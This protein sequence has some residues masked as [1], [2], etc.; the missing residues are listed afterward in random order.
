MKAKFLRYINT[1]LE[2]AIMVLV[3]VSFGGCATKYGVG[4]EPVV[5]EYGAP[6]AT[7]EVSGSVT[8]EDSKPA[9]GIRVTVQS[10][11]N[12]LLPETYSEED[13]LYTIKDGGAFPMPHIEIIAEDTSGMY[14]PDT[15]R[16]DVQYDRSSVSKDEGWNF[17]KASIIQ[18]F[19]LKKKE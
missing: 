9:A 11:G 19:Q 7:F 5:A 16:V 3:G 17:G 1:F 18:D 2:T 12:P 14:A 15:A 10:D 8:N 6:Y 4:P 13:G